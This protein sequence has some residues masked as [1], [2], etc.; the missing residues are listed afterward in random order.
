MDNNKSLEQLNED[1]DKI[2]SLIK[3]IENL[4]LEDLEDL[5]KESIFIKNSLKDR[6]EQKDSPKTNPSKA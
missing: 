1:I 3:K 2:M 4:S 5:K 6:Y